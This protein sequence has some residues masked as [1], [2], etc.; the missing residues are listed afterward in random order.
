MYKTAR[1]AAILGIGLSASAVVGW[2]LLKENKRPKSP[3]SVGTSSQYTEMEPAPEIVLPLDTLEETSGV[4]MNA[5]TA[6]ISG[7]D[8]L[9]RIRDIG[10]RFAQ[11][12][13]ESGITSYE[14]LAAETPES[15]A[16][17]LAPHQIRVSAERIQ[18]KDWI[19][20]AAQLAAQRD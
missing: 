10:P 18:T 9:T 13:A 7:A 4:P 3:A 19:G 2:L 16:E 12:L 14:Q 17:R 6:P 1:H 15:L 5:P 8:D 11:A 20:Q